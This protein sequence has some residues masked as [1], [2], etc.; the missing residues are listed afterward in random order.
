MHTDRI[1]FYS[2]RFGKGYRADW[3]WYLLGFLRFVRENSRGLCFSD[4][5]KAFGWWDLFV[6]A[7]STVQ[8]PLYPCLGACPRVKE[9]L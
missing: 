1:L 8:F 4:C 2:G 5:L 6:N 3:F 7:L 9:V